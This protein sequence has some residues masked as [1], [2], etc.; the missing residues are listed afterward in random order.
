VI[1]SRD[2][3]KSP[4]A[5]FEIYAGNLNLTVLRTDGNFGCVHCTG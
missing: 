1:V 4:N 5:K 2:V 3:M